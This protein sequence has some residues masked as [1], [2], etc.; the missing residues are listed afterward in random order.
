MKL[1]KINFLIL[2]FISSF[3]TIVN[4]G[5]GPASVYKIQIY[6]IEVCD[7]TSTATEC[8]NA[9][10]IYDSTA[11]SG[12]IDIAATTAGATAASLGNLN[13]AAIG[14]EYTY[15]QVTMDRAFT[16]SGY[17]TDDNSNTCYTDSGE[18]GSATSA[19]KGSNS[20]ETA[21][22]LYAA[23]ESSALDD[24]LS[25]MAS[26]TDTSPTDNTI[27]D[28][29]T[30]FQWRIKLTSSLIIRGGRIPTAKIAF[31]TSNAVGAIDNMTAACNAS[32]DAKGL[33]AAAPDVIITFK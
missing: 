13:K 19:A 25:G 31:G 12:D 23:F 7:N 29:D 11:G 14:T 3:L 27:A 2:F 30:H 9:V 1:F 18:A 32:G 8:E 4:A 15:M 33:Y 5:T 22:T 24:E 16:V 6:K 10:A 26:L 17:A 28:G 20:A 21:T